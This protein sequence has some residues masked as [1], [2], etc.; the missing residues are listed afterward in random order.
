M[1]E[2]ILIIGSHHS[3]SCSLTDA[4]KNVVEEEQK[5][6]NE[7]RQTFEFKNYH[8]PDVYSSPLIMNRSQR[9]KQEK[10]DRKKPKP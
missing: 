8:I 4:V 3:S 2:N 1:K 6:I 9:R 5:N 10:I 7:I